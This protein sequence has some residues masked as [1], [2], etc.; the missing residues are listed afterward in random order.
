VARAV[1][2]PGIGTFLV[3]AVLIVVTIIGSVWLKRKFAS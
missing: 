1:R 2:D 3:L